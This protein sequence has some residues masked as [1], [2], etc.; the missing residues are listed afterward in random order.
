MVFPKPNRLSTK[1]FG[2]PRLLCNVL[3]KDVMELT[4]EEAVIKDTSFFSDTGG[5]SQAIGY[6]GNRSHLSFV[7][8]P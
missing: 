7:F 5:S 3:T 8:V 2:E 4:I 6:V 1:L